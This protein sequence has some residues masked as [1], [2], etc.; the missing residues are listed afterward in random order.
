[1]DPRGVYGI[2]IG[3]CIVQGVKGIRVLTDIGNIEE[4]C[5]WK[6]YWNVVPYGPPGNRLLLSSGVFGNEKET[7]KFFSKAKAKYVPTAATDLLETDDESAVFKEKEAQNDSEH[8]YERTVTSKIPAT[9]DL[10]KF[11]RRL[12]N[13]VDSDDSLESVKRPIAVSGGNAKTDSSDDN[14]SL[15]EN[16]AAKKTDVTT[17][18]ALRDDIGCG[19]RLK[20]THVKQSDRKLTLDCTIK[21]YLLP[22][23]GKITGKYVGLVKRNEKATKTLGLKFIGA[24]PICE[25]TPS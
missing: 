15:S 5:T 25:R 6:S 2:F 16:E 13:D 3:N 24:M 20:E 12:T 8:A 23:L 22:P 21:F 14:D 11:S 1:M 17:Q 19:R 9:R 18:K 7:T 4:F 10:S